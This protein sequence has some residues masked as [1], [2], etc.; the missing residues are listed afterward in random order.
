M[1]AGV[2]GVIMRFNRLIFCCVQVSNLAIQFCVGVLL[3]ICIYDLCDT[4][5]LTVHISHLYLGLVPIHI[6][7]GYIY[8]NILY[9]YTCCF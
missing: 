9:N 4:H 6:Y 5:N 3:L 7:T 1:G 2:K 8:I